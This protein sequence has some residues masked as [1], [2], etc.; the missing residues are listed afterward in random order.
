MLILIAMTDKE[1]ALRGMLLYISFQAYSAEWRIT[2]SPDNVVSSAPAS[3]FSKLK[4]VPTPQF[5]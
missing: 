2:Q 1:S 3:Q 4:N 5:P